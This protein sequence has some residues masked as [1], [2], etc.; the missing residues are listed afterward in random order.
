MNRIL[1]IALLLCLQACSESTKEVKTDFPIAVQ[2]FRADSVN[3]TTAYEFPA[4]V[5]AVKNV[6]LKFEI[7]GRLVFA[8]LVEGSMVAKGQ[9][10][11]RIDPTP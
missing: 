1:L 4:A 5:S 10:L 2:L 7:S 6:D 11:A 8:N 3:I 9:V